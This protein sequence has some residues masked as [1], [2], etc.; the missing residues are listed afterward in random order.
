MWNRKSTQAERIN[1]REQAGRMER[2]VVGRTS[3]PPRQMTGRENGRRG[4]KRGSKNLNINR[5]R[6]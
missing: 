3:N 4:G 2:N 5:D 1:F 6:V